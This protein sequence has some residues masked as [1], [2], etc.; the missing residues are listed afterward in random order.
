MVLNQL[1]TKL[2]DP[3]SFSIPCMIGSVSINRALCNLGSSVSL[4]PYSI[5][6]RLG[7]GELSPTSIFL[8]LA[9]CSIKYHWVF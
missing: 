1:P 3:S 6:K 4:M 8:Q 2:K 5:F 9:D 7:Q